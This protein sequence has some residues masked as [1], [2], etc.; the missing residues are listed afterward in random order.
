MIKV[1]A[2][3]RFNIIHPAHVQFLKRAKALGDQLVVVVASDETIKNA[4]KRAVFPERER[5]KMVAA[6]KPVDKAVIGY[7]LKG[8]SGYQRIIKKE[9]P[10][11]IALG[12]DQLVDQAAL[13]QM[14]RK[15]G[16]TC[17]IVRIEKYKDYQTKNIVR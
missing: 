16:T 14:C 4:G 1:L 15:A 12:Y 9:K 8:E 17:T 13:K 3:G 11:I 10:D 7:A 6:L 2:G 5:Q